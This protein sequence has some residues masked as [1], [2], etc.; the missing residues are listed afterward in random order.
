VVDDL[1]AGRLA[2]LLDQTIPTTLG[3]YLVM[4]QNRTTSGKVETFRD[5][6][7]EQSSRQQP[8]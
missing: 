6:L 8:A 7:L 4:P 5:W 2:R 1:Q 3:Y